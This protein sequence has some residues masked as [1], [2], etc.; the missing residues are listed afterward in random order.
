M[1][2]K[3]LMS[4]SLLSLSISSISSYRY[5]SRCSAISLPKSSSSS[6]SSSSLSSSNIK[7]DE[8]RK[9]YSSKGLFE[10]ELPIDPMDLFSNWF[11]EACSSNVLEPNAMCLATCINNIPSS[12]YV[13]LK[14]HDSRGF[15]WYT[16][17][18]SRK[19]KELEANPNAALTFWYG[20]LERSI[21]IE[22]KVEKVSAEEAD[23][24]FNSR[25]RTS[26]IGAWTS[27]QSSEISDRNALGK[28][29]LNY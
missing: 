4:L 25:P 22:G 16:N 12:R 15:V 28:Y 21:R 3:S 8:L 24:Y 5:V 20:T 17:Y 19:S 29:H 23:T 18:N 6:S 11:D 26:Q 10:S 2:S 13:L 9:E 7:I 1:L 14:A 27:N